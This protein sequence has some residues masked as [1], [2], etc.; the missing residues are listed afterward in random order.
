MDYRETYRD[1]GSVV[2]A[3]EPHE[4]VYEQLHRAPGTVLVRGGGIVA[5][6]VLQRLIDDRDAHGPAD[7]DPARRSARTSTGPHGPH[8]W[9]RRPG[10]DGWA[11]QGF[12]YPKSVWGGQLKAQMR[13]L[14][15]EDR[16][17]LYKVIG[18]T[19]TPNRRVLAGPDAPGA[20]GGLV[21]DL[22]GRDRDDGARPARHR[23]GA[24]EDRDGA[25]AGAGHRA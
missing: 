7:P 16:A 8:A 6:R 15:G 19:N 3:Y 17:A 18:G 1:F 21:P 13:K 5:S 14:E 9:M 4:H 23:P 2:N 20:A 22:P 12:N 24:A 10:G 25:R 11:Y